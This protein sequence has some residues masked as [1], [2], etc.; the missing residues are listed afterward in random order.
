MLTDDTNSYGYYLEHYGTKYEKPA[1]NGKTVGTNKCVG[2]CRYN[3]HRGFITKDLRKQH[4]C[5]K[6][7]C[8]FYVPKS[9]ASN[10]SCLGSSGDY[11]LALQRAAALLEAE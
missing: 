3:G 10:E 7:G 9:K 4:N 11:L 1:F 2:F 8:A 5:C 6:K